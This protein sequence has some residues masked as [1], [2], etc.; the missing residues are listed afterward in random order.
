MFDLSDLESFEKLKKMLQYPDFINHM[1]SSIKN[2]R[3]PLMLLIGCK[4][5]L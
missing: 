4:S 3:S 2:E 1:E 5:D